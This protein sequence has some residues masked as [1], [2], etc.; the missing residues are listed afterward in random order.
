MISDEGISNLLLIIIVGSLL[1]SYF[2]ENYE[3]VVEVL[4][5]PETAEKSQ[6]RRV[7][8]ELGLKRSYK[9]YA[10]NFL[11]PKRPLHEGEIP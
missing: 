4:Y 9:R 2:L 11:D 8:N 3:N 5:E 10:N 6:A 7:R 1:Y